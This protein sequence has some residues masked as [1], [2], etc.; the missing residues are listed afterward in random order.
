MKKNWSKKL[1]S[2]MLFLSLAATTMAI[3]SPVEASESTV[4]DTVM[5][6]ASLFDYE[7]STKGSKNY[8]MFTTAEHSSNHNYGEYNYWTKD[9][10]Y[11]IQQGLVKNTL[12]STGNVVLANNRTT[13]SAKSGKL[14][15]K[16]ELVGTYQMPFK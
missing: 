1:L 15:Q 14:F 8:L 3:S 10:D 13:P 5:A 16:D 11:K 9:N 6:T 12:D 4:P 7:R 2:I